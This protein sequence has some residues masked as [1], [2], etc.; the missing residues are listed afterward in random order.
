MT[1]AKQKSRL[2]SV[3]TAKPLREQTLP[4]E[5]IRLQK[6]PDNLTWDEF[7]VLARKQFKI[8]Q[9]NE[10][11]RLKDKKQQQLVFCNAK[12][13]LQAKLDAKRKA[14]KQLQLQ[15][16]KDEE[17]R[18]K[19]IVANEK[20]QKEEEQRKRDEE[21]QKRREEEE[22]VRRKQ[23]EEQRRKQEEEHK[24]QQELEKKQ[25]EEDER[26]KQ[27]EKDDA[28]N[29]AQMDMNNSFLHL[30]AT[31]A[32]PNFDDEIEVTE[33]Q[34]AFELKVLGG[35]VKP[36]PDDLRDK[37]EEIGS[38]LS[39]DNV[40]FA[41]RNLK[42]IG[43]SMRKRKRTLFE[44]DQGKSNAEDPLAMS[45]PTIQVHEIKTEDGHS[46]SGHITRSNSALAGV[47]SPPAKVFQGMKRLNETALA[48]SL[49]AKRRRTGSTPSRPKNLTPSHQT[50]GVEHCTSHAEAKCKA[51][52]LGNAFLKSKKLTKSNSTT[53]YN[54]IKEKLP[55][56]GL[57]WFK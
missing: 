41:L 48:S 27:K 7:T 22:E 24:R 53:I 45:P 23:E 12:T 18:Q 42:Q 14:N 36:E 49:T 15:K 55:H 3:I 13:I 35:K 31:D 1:F 19:Q 5:Y 26:R 39:D 57:R 37:L 51:S 38:L 11:K 9:E 33:E 34:L 52:D 21:E 54:A 29:Q 17:E 4:D 2:I 50:P 56:K 40:L 43:S 6:K 16:Q 44:V 46:P 28:K 25:R 47:K 20:R 32:D 30:M 10:L 8:D